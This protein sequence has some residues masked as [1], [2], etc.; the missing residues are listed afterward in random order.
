MKKSS[1][2]AIIII[3]FNFFLSSLHNGIQSTVKFLL[4]FDYIYIYIYKIKCP[5]KLNIRPDLKSHCCA[6]SHLLK[7]KIKEKGL[8]EPPMS[9]TM[10]T[11]I[12]VNRENCKGVE[13]DEPG[14]QQNRTVQRNEIKKKEK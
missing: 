4:S 2:H 6:F 3:Y 13:S 9:F 8:N 10:L 5:V 7:K 12:V 14:I 1:L 11:R